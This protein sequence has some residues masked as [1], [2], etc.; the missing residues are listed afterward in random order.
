MADKLIIGVP[1]QVL[2]DNANYK[3]SYLR[4]NIWRSIADHPGY[5][6]CE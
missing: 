6:N 2:F 1:L 4:D 5:A 3:N